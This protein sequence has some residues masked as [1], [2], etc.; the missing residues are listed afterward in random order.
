MRTVIANTTHAIS[1]LL[2]YYRYFYK[3][4][5]VQHAALPA[6]QSIE[7][8]YTQHLTPCNII[9]FSFITIIIL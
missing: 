3:I 5:I 7:F 8:K 4:T 1:K 6:L 2:I 9:K